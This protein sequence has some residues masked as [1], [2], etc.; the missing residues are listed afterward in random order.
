MRI[1]DTVLY[2]AIHADLP[3]I[4]V[5]VND[6]GTVNGKVVTDSHDGLEWATNVREGDSHGTWSAVTHDDL[7]I[8]VEAA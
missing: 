4:V 5:R 7:H 2:H 3:M 8:H 6:D 1:G